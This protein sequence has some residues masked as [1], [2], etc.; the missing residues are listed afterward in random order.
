MIISGWCCGGDVHQKVIG[1]IANISQMTRY[2][3]R[4]TVTM[5]EVFEVSVVDE[6]HENNKSGSSNIGNIILKH[7]YSHINL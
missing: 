7:R 4:H 1:I 6:D 5:Q 2:E 3:I